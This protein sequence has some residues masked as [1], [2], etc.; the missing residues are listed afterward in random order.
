MT[1][2]Y[3]TDGLQGQ[4]IAA[5]VLLEALLQTLQANTRLS[6]SSGLTLADA[7]TQSR[8]VKQWKPLNVALD[9]RTPMVF[10]IGR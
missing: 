9:N 10:A 4:L 2:K 7:S 5:T 3:T 1:E 6:I 8:L